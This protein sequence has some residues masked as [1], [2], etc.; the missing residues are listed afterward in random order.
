MLILGSNDIR[1]ELIAEFATHRIIATPL[2]LSAEQASLT[3]VGILIEPGLQSAYAA[4]AIAVWLVKYK[5]KRSALYTITNSFGKREEISVIDPSLPELPFILAQATEITILKR[6]RVRSPKRINPPAR[7]RTKLIDEVRSVCPNPNCGKSG[8]TY[9]QAHHIDGE[10]SATTDDNLLMLCENCH[11][12]ADKHLISRDTVVF[13]K[14]LVRQGLHPYLDDPKR[15]IEKATAPVV[16]GNNYGHAAQRMSVHYH[17]VKR[18]PVANP[19]TIETSPPHRA[20]VYYLG[21]KYIEWRKKG[22]TEIGDERPFNPAAAW[23]VIQNELGFAPYK[24]L[25]ESFETVQEVI[26]AM[27]DRTPFG[28]YNTANNKRNYHTFDEHKAKMVRRRSKGAETP[29]K[30]DPS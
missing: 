23:S 24:A 13:W 7:L 10:R 9:L 27:I 16:D 18:K 15:K 8:V 21:Q 14:R 4:K 5:S 20:Y 12:E 29:N 19:G 26:K 17:G 25:L 11:G 28:S 30:I 1:D 22:I 2:V 3:T 6:K